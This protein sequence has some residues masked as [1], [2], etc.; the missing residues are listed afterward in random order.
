MTPG[1]WNV[2]QEFGDQLHLPSG[3]LRIM[4]AGVSSLFVYYRSGLSL[5]IWLLVFVWLGV[6]GGT[7]KGPKGPQTQGVGPSFSRKRVEPW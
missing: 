6:G 4:E 3:H 5:Q 7:V 1:L 2:L